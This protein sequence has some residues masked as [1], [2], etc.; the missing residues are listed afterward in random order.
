[1]QNVAK[2]R[3][4]MEI[5]DAAV[6]AFSQYLV[7]RKDKILQSARPFVVPKMV[8][9]T[10][11]LEKFVV[12][13]DDSR[14]TKFVKTYTIFGQTIEVKFKSFQYEEKDYA[15]NVRVVKQIYPDYDDQT[16]LDSTAALYDLMVP[17]EETKYIQRIM[18]KKFRN[19]EIKDSVTGE[20]LVG[21]DLGLDFY[22]LRQAADS[23]GQMSI[24]TRSSIMRLSHGTDVISTQRKRDLFQYLSELYRNGAKDYKTSHKLD[25]L[26]V[27]TVIVDLDS[28]KLGDDAI[29]SGVSAM[30]E[31]TNPYQN[32]N[33]SQL[34]SDI[35]NVTQVGNDNRGQSGP[36]PR[37]NPAPRPTGGNPVAGG[38]VKPQSK[39]LDTKL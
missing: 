5:T 21:F 39:K 2:T 12:P 36:L 26:G 13:F 1:M 22:G 8:G 37:T 11:K 31:V 9:G 38:K 16:N 14:I 6:N 4:I 35:F 18:P 28:K 30:P 10:Q 29:I 25:K 20:S 3:L 24:A 17:I 15:G 33:V 27:D 23:K 34:E 32:R 19:L 7:R